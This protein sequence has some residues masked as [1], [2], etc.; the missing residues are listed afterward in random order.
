MKTAMVR[1]WGER[2]EAFADEKGVVRVYDPIAGYYTVTAT[3]TLNQER[4]VRQRTQPK[5]PAASP[6]V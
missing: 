6:S 3:L 4:Y 1:V 2:H 5:V